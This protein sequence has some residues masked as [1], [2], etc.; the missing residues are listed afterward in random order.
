M[1]KVQSEAQYLMYSSSTL[2]ICCILLIY[3]V[4]LFLFLDF[5]IMFEAV[6]L[7]NESLT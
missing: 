5:F 7:L 3:T 2:D 1:L 4:K 6:G